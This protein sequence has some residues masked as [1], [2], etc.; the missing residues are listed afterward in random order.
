MIQGLVVV[1]PLTFRAVTYG[2]SVAAAG[3]PM[4][5]RRSSPASIVTCRNSGEPVT[6]S[7]TPGV[8]GYRPMAA[9]TYHEL[10]APTSCLPGS[11][12]GI[13]FYSAGNNR[14]KVANVF[15]C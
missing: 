3:A 8:C 6:S 11:P 5:I 1:Q 10:I 12:T 15:Q 14:H 7:G 9:Q 2:W 13:V 4:S